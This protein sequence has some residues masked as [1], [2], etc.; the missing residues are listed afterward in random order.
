MQRWGSGEGGVGRGPI[1]EA[2]TKGWVPARTLALMTGWR[3]A[4]FTEMGKIV[5]RINGEMNRE[6]NM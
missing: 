6:T 4:P 5:E 1:S 3:V 2:R